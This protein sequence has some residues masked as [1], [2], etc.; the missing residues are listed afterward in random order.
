MSAISTQFGSS[1]MISRS[2][3]AVMARTLTQIS[4]GRAV[5]SA[6]DNAAYWSISTVMSSDSKA[7]SAVSDALNLGAATTDTASL[8]MS[9]SLSLMDQIKQKLVLARQDG[10]DKTKINTEISSLK[11]QLAS[12]VQSA[13][14]S[15]V[16]L[17]T[18]TT[19]SAP[20]KVDMVSGFTRSENGDVRVTVSPVDTA[21]TTLV[22]TLNPQ[23]G[24]LTGDVTVNQTNGPAQ[25]HLLNGASAAPGTEIALSANTSAEDID[26]MISAVDSMMSKATSA[27]TTLG[28]H[29]SGIKA[30]SELTAKIM[31]SLEEGAAKLVDT[32]MGEQSAR[33]A[34]VTVQIQLQAQMQSIANAN[35][36]AILDLFR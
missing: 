1:G 27:A 33:L 23:N 25:Y 9:Q 14:F 18:N 5:A 21:E 28:A 26:G 30:N 17:L 4:T 12:T 2:N 10:V 15:G 7:L 36:K 3:Q 20:G 13:S 35:A 24:I 11:E 31:D 8:G 29:S 34:A 19:G 6:S 32:D 16:N 22:D